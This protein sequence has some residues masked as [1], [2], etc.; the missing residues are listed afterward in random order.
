MLSFD[1][2]SVNAKELIATFESSN[3]VGNSSW[4]KQ[5]LSLVGS[6]WFEWCFF[7]LTWND[8]R[9]VNRRV[10]LLASHDVEAESLIRFGQFDDARMGVTFAG[11]KGRYCRLKKK[12]SLNKSQ[13]WSCLNLRILPW[14]WR[15]PGFLDC[16]RRQPFHKH[17]HRLLERRSRIRIVKL[18]ATR[19]IL[20]L[21][22]RRNTCSFAVFL[23][24]H[25]LFWH[26]EWNQKLTF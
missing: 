17:A 10:L 15:K 22:L 5:K 25:M 8:S 26:L 21:G 3:P 4:K 11:G 13:Q 14:Q 20:W 6:L 2:D 7:V 19:P 18:F 12:A 24:T 16:L 9:Y 23:A 1:W